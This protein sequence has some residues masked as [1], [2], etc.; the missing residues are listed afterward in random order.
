MD[1]FVSFHL[2][3]FDIDL[4]SSIR[5]NTIKKTNK[6]TVINLNIVINENLISRFE[7]QH[8]AQS[9]QILLH[10]GWLAGEHQIVFW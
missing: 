3:E 9:A 4:I 10:L 5:P 8:K 1:V 7:F 6:N 2:A